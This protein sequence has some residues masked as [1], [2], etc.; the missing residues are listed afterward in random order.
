LDLAIHLA[1]LRSAVRR[2]DHLLDGVTYPQVRD[3]FDTCRVD[4]RQATELPRL[5][6]EYGKEEYLLPVDATGAA[7]APPQDVVKDYRAHASRHPGFEHWLQEAVLGHGG[8][9]IL[10][11]ARWLCHLVGFRHRTVE[12]FLDHPFIA[13]YTLVQVRSLAKVEAPGC[14]DLPA[15]GHIAGTASP[16]EGLCQELEEELGLIRNDISNLQQIG[17]YDHADPMS[18]SGLHNVEYRTVFAGRLKV[19]ALQRIRFVDHEVAAIAVCSLTEIEMLLDTHPERVASG[20]THS[21]PLYL[22]TRSPSGK[23]V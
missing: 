18:D 16:Q 11:V 15:A 4:Q 1:Q 8:Q 14:F 10:L 5:A 20:L 12:L 21:W 6:P 22:A 13:E 2:A 3:V 17:S 7:H 9:P 23:G 19:D